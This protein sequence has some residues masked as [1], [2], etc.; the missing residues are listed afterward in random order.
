MRPSGELY[1][2][3]RH[4]LLKCGEF[5]NDASLRAVFTSN[6]L[7]PFRNRLP[8]ATNKNERLDVCLAFLIDQRV[9]GGQPV[10]PLFL[11][12][13]R[14]RYQPG[15][16]LY[17][18]LTDLAET[19]RS[20]LDPS[21][22]S[23]SGADLTPQPQGTTYITHIGHAEGLAIG[24]G[25]RVE[26]PRVD[27]V[28]DGNVVGDGSSSHVVKGETAPSTARSGGW[29]T[30]AIREML[31]A[32][33]SDS[34]LTTLCFDHFYT[35]YEN[36]GAGMGKGQKIQRLLDHCVRQAQFTELIRRVRE[37]NPAQYAR[38]EDRLRK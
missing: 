8:T 34:D 11:T 35:V 17:D 31:A 38:F 30:A 16:A 14:D 21:R 29:N 20:H 15:D 13:L 26:A 10:L 33:F 12:A 37:R 5:D 19:T 18:E 6:A 4:T 25:A 7:Y 24:D 32:A 28:G 3:C 27:I 23:L 1:R 22:A 36:F 9:S 2:R